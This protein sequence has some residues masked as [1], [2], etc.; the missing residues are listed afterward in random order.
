MIRQA[1]DVDYLVLNSMC[2]NS[3]DINRISINGDPFC[4]LF[5]Y[6]LDEKIIGFI[7]YSIIYERSELN[8]LYV[9][10]D[11]RRKHI[12]S[13]LM[14]FM[15]NDV[16]IHKCHN[17]TLEVSSINTAGIALYRKYG[18]IAKAIRK[19]YYHDSDGILMI[20]ELIVNE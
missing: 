18:F 10:N 20:R 8:Y 9:D 15:L 1:T 7:C 3:F 17:I 4:K 5:V 2:R 13:A 14:E 11:Y 6:E 12:A 19:N 16:V